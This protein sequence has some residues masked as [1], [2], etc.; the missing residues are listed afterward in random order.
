MCV[1]GWLGYIK[2]EVLIAGNPRARGARIIRNWKPLYPWCNSRLVQTVMADRILI[3]IF[4]IFLSLTSREKWKW[5][6]DITHRAVAWGIRYECLVILNQHTFIFFRVFNELCVCAI[7]KPW[8]KASHFPL[9]FA[10]RMLH[11]V[12]VPCEMDIFR[13]QKEKHNKPSSITHH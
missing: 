12:M 8:Q 13:E 1:W 4:F 6:S 11:A 3:L 10:P 9:Q 7:Q 2:E 5:Q